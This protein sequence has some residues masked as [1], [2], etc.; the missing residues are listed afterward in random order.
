MDFQALTTCVLEIP[1]AAIHFAG[2]P[3]IRWYTL[4]CAKKTMAD[5]LVPWRC[6]VLACNNAG[7]QQRNR[8]TSY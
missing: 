5:L 7:F 1:A 4:Q 8:Q 2:A 3:D 6:C